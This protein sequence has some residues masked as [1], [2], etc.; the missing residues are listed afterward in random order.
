MKILYFPKHSSNSF[1][2]ILVFLQLSRILD[3]LCCTITCN[4]PEYDIKRPGKFHFWLV[5]LILEMQILLII[6]KNNI[7]TIYYI[8]FN[9]LKSKSFQKVLFTLIPVNEDLE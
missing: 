4:S 6:T 7:S 3:C 2:V 9:I 1:S 8:I 5:R